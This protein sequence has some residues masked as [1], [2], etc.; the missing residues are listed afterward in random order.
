M[1]DNISKLQFVQ[2]PGGES[3]ANAMISSEGEMM[4]YRKGVLAEGKVHTQ[5]QLL[6][7]HQSQPSTVEPSIRDP[8]R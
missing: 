7:C 1:F 6:P 5:L 4:T 8:L 3:I 2:S